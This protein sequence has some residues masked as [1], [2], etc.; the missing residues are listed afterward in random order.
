M[1][2]MSKYPDH[3]PVIANAANKY[4]TQV[5]KNKFLVPK[6]FNVSQFL[7]ILRKNLDLG[8]E[9]ALFVT[10]DNSLVCSSKNFQQIH[11]ESKKNDGILYLTYTK[12]DTF[13]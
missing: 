4:V 7:Y 1:E 11:F 12:E 5:K 9:S 2:L 8:S 10:V 13:G 6:D 3:V